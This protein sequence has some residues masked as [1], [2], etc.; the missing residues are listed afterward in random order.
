[1]TLLKNTSTLSML[2][3][4]SKNRVLI[5]TNKNV[6]DLCSMLKLMNLINVAF[7]ILNIK[8]VNPVIFS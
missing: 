8:S 5:G 4:N 2:A 7:S 3:R 6:I 1:M